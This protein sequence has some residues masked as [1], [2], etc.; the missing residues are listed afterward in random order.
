[1]NLLLYF[2]CTAETGAIPSDFAASGL[3]PCFNGAFFVTFTS[4]A[5]SEFGFGEPLK[6]EN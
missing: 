1:M 4:Y 2:L 6:I 3:Y 5:A